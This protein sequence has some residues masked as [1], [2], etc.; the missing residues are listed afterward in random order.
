LLIG[1]LAALFGGWFAW[2]SWGRVPLYEVSSSARIETGEHGRPVETVLPGRVARVIV[3]LGE[4]VQKGAV[5]VEL[6]DTAVRSR[7]KGAETELTALTMQLEARQS[8]RVLTEQLMDERIKQ[9]EVNLSQ[10]R[11]RREQAEAAS[12]LA[13]YTAKQRKQLQEKGIISESDYLQSRSNSVQKQ[14]ELKSTDIELERLRAQS[15]VEQGESRTHLAELSARIAELEASIAR[16]RG[17]LE[18]LHKEWDD[19]RVRATADG[20]IGE[21]ADIRPGS[22]VAT[23]TRI[24][25]IVPTGVL[26]A[27]AE[28]IPAKAIGLVAPG[29]SA[30][31]RLDG[32]SQL[33]NTA[34]CKR[35]SSM[36]QE[37]SATERFA[38]ISRSL[39]TAS[40]RSRCNTANPALFRSRLG[41]S[42]QSSSSFA[43]GCACSRRMPRH[44]RCRARKTGAGNETVVS[45]LRPGSRGHPDLVHR[46]RSRLAQQP[47]RRL[48]DPS[49]LRETARSLPDH[50]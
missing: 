36:L 28:F 39:R 9:T 16:R 6:D 37:K 7:I 41:G 3:R 25:T 26:H 5:V 13:D 24:A 18:S 8:E 20:L 49:K 47:A 21:L 11:T 48:R 32:A 12:Q 1:I 30:R 50:A 19:H 34:R 45:P 38:S 27:V 40:P 35:E 4:T 46:L 22:F 10:A 14:A 42:L 31:I 29:Q 33:P 2:L 43:P 23:G 44:S 17:E 15:M